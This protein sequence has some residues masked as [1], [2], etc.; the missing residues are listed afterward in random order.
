MAPKSTVLLA[1]LAVL[2]SSLNVGLVVAHM[3]MSQPLPMRSQY[4][5]TIPEE[6]KDYNLKSPLDAN[7]DNFPCHGYQNDRPIVAKA[8][9]KA[10]SQYTMTV[11]GTATHGGGSKSKPHVTDG[12][13]ANYRSRLPII[14]VL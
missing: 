8:A 7:G 10:G 12:S 11:A 5:P 13:V 3:E 9:Y 6:L 4:D 14:I 2:L 1:T